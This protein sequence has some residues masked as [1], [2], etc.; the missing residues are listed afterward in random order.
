[1][2]RADSA[3]RVRATPAAQHPSR[4]R[5]F[6]FTLIEVLVAMAV[7]SVLAVIAYKGVERMT[8]TKQALDVE[9]RRWRDLT[10][11][12]GRFEE[13]LG[14]VVNRPWR[15]EGG[16]TQPALRGGA[17]GVDSNGA[18]LE[19]VRFDGGRLIHLGYRL[20]EGRLEMLLWDSLDLA[21]RTEPQVLKLL[22]GVERIDL[23]FLDMGGQWQL[24]WPQGSYAYQLPRGVEVK[25]TLANGHTLQRLVA[26]P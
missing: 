9:N 5:A 20:R 12:M 8:L 6:G 25:L 10:L 17:G 18:Q 7:F 16:L 26:L 19:L 14:Q 11:V 22:D 24:S 23:R 1:M 15:D 4:R 13:D 3:R 21:P 2:S